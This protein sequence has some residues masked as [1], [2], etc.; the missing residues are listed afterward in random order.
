M[1]FHWFAEA[2]YP[3]LPPDFH[4]VHRSAWV[5]PS[6]KLL[7][8]SLGGETLRSYL[9]MY[10][11]AD[12]VGFDGVLVNEHHQTAGAMTPSPNLMAAVLAE[13]T[14]KAAIAIVG[15]SLA[16]YNPPVRVA[17]EYAFLDAISNGRLI[18]GFVYGSPMDSVYSYGVP[19][20]EVRDR[21]AEAHDLIMKAWQAGAPFSFN[22]KYT[23]LRYVNIWPRPIQQPHPPIWVPGSGSLETWALVNAKDYCYGH[24]SF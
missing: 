9:R 18:A 2:T 1:K 20:A 13:T 21:F 15:N 4:K 22:G 23:K 8:P 24:L 11:Y 16:L 6:P 12:E 3:H 14:K 5:D 10:Q 17:E 7:D 19:P